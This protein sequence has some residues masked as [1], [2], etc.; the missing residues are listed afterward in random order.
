MHTKDTISSLLDPMRKQ[1]WMIT[2]LAL[3][4][5]LH[6]YGVTMAEEVDTDSD[7]MA[8]TYEQQIIDADANDDIVTLADVLPDDDFDRDGRTNTEEFA[9]ETDPTDPGSTLGLL[10]YYPFNGNANDESGRAQHGT[11]AGGVTL[12]VDR[13]G[14]ATNAYDLDGEDGRIEL[15][16]LFSGDQDPLTVSAWVNLDTLDGGAPDPEDGVFPIYIELRDNDGSARNHA[17]IH[18]NQS[19]ELTFEQ[20]GPSGGNVEVNADLKDEIG[21]WVQVAIVKENDVVYAYKNGLL[22]GSAPHTETYNS[23]APTLAAIGARMIGI[24]WVRGYAGDGQIDDVRIYDRALSSNE[25]AR[26]Y[27]QTALPV[28]L[29]TVTLHPGD[30]GSIAE[31]NSGADYVVSLT[32][33]AAFPSVTVTPD[34]GYSVTG[35]SPSA[36]ATLTNDFE[37]T[38]VYTGIHPMWWVTR[39]VLLETN[40]AVHLDYAVMTQGEVKYLAQQTAAEFEAQLPGGAGSNIIALVNSFQNTNNYASLN[41]G[42]LKTVAQPFYDRLWELSLTNA[43]PPGIIHKYPWM[44]QP[45]NNYQLVNLGQAKYLFS[46][47]FAFLLDIDDDGDG[48][49][50]NQGDCDDASSA[51]H[52]GANE[53]DGDGVDNNCNGDIDE[54]LSLDSRFYKR[55]N[56]VVMDSQTGLEWVAGPEM[57]I[58]IGMKCE[59]GHKA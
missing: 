39:G 58:P 21:R 48:Y 52:P 59:C 37:A 34:A 26:L 1:V 18:H 5:I 53:V 31:A 13:F 8:D 10:A 50:E 54:I 15:P 25:V 56:G 44:G 55:T 41:E 33:G 32:N 28:D 17:L 16:V 49:T 7:G 45:T 24:S 20:Y 14:N 27:E 12:T 3:A 42:Q 22:Q 38:A 47:S 43:Y 51:I 30:H 23:S 2:M 29:H 4:G 19:G 36:P 11:P 6:P 35:W 46:F 9:D 40:L 57:S